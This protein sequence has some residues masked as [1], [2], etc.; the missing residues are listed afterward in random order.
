MTKVIFFF[1]LLTG[2]ACA[3]QNSLNASYPA[4]QVSYSKIVLVNE[5]ASLA[6]ICSGTTSGVLFVDNVPTDTGY[7]RLETCVNGNVVTSYQGCFNR[8]CTGPR[9][10]TSGSSAAY[11]CPSGYVEP[12]TAG[13]SVFVTPVGYSIT[14][15]TCCQSACAPN[16]SSSGTYCTGTTFTDSQCGSLCNGTKTCAPSAVCG[17]C[18]IN[19][20]CSNCKVGGIASDGVCC[21]GTCLPVGS[22]GVYCC[23]SF[24][25]ADN[26]S[27][28]VGTQECN[29]S[30]SVPSGCLAV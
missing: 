24:Y 13:S 10:T 3:G 29:P 1:I 26:W 19:S 20:D 6:T 17:A 8:F 14:S 11:P 15:I 28:T 2:Y 9:C 23:T 18:S 12:S 16:C 30:G 22:P 4:Q 7:G 21:A 5:S 25:S 27:C